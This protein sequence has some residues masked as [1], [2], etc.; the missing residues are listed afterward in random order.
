MI[1]RAGC[2]CMPNGNG[3]WSRTKIDNEVLEESILF[4][5]IETH[6]KNDRAYL[7]TIKRILE[8][9]DR[10]KIANKYKSFPFYCRF[11][12]INRWVLK[13]QIYKMI[14]EKKIITSDGR[15]NSPYYMLNTNYSSEIEE[16]EK[17][18]LAELLVSQLI[19]S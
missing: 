3:D 2:Y 11:P 16:E 9:N 18:K 19:G 5:L 6:K 15:S 8:G 1:L 10:S 14:E 4:V 17:K 12:D 7:D 13:T